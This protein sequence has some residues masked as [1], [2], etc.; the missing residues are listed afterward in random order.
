MVVRGA[1]TTRRSELSGSLSVLMRETRRTRSVRASAMLGTRAW[2][3]PFFLSDVCMR[4]AGD[5]AQPFRYLRLVISLHLWVP[6]KAIAWVLA[7]WPTLARW[8]APSRATVPCSTGPE[9]AWT[10]KLASLGDTCATRVD[11]CYKNIVVKGRV[12]F[13]KLAWLYLRGGGDSF[14]GSTLG[15][16]SMISDRVYHERRTCMVCYCV[17]AH[18]QLDVGVFFGPNG[19][20]VTQKHKQVHKHTNDTTQANTAPHKNTQEGIRLV[21]LL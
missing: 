21:V 5:D 18:D 17:F 11:E 15:V 2:F 3:S 20:H 16:W 12:S 10:R 7:A 8:K 1:S 9:C 4:T 6:W 14:V 13:F 19:S